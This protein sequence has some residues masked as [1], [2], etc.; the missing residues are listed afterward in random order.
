MKAHNYVLHFLG[1]I[2]SV[3][4]ETAPVLDRLPMAFSHPFKENSQALLASRGDP[5]RLT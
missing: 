5:V 4:F 3:A 1:I 2:A